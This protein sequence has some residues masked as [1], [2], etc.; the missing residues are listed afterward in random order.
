MKGVIYSRCRGVKVIDITHDIPRHDIWAGAYCMFQA[1]PFFPGG[2]IHVA[3]V[4]PGVGTSRR[5][6]ILDDGHH[7]FV[8][9]DNGVLSLVLTLPYRRPLCAY[10]IRDPW[11]MRPNPSET[12]HGRDI[13]A[14]AAGRL[15]RGALPKDAGPRIKAGDIVDLRKHK[16]DDDSAH[17]RAYVIH[18][19]TFGNII[20]DL[21]SS[22]IPASPTFHVGH[23]TIHG[24]Q[25]TYSDVGV[26]ELVAYVGSQNTL[27]LAVRE[28]SAMD[29]LGLVRG[30]AIQVGIGEQ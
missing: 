12:F 10:E 23:H 15:A 22:M 17:P 2:T 5:P 4:D 7:F 14:A 27:E 6:I 24:V 26:G 16:D 1:S 3:V 30:M 20:T 11:F 13:F 19:D 25:K 21:N 9:P 18:I 29:Q 8:G 28:G